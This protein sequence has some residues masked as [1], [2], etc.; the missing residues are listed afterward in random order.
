MDLKIF[1]RVSFSKARQ[2]LIRRHLA[3]G[4][5]ATYEEADKRAVENDLVNGAQIVELLNDEELDVLVTSVEDEG[6]EHA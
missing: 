5:A 4:L 6:W 1:V 3:A 2:R